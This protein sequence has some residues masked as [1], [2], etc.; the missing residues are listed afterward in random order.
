MI[1]SATGVDSLPPPAELTAA[2]GWLTAVVCKRGHGDSTGDHINGVRDRRAAAGPASL[3]LRQ[4]VC[5]VERAAFDA[6]SVS[7]LALP[8]C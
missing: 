6:A 5:I 7:T 3:V 1:P 8:S 2:A 4:R